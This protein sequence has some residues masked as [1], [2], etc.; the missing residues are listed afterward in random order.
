M[1]VSDRENDIIKDAVAEPTEKRVP[2]KK[3]TGKRKSGSRKKSV[4]PSENT[5]EKKAEMMPNAPKHAITQTQEQTT[6]TRKTRRDSQLHSK[7]SWITAGSK[8]CAM[9][10]AT[11]LCCHAAGRAPAQQLSGGSDD[12]R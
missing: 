4:Q 6:L 10:L 2:A 9:Q 5:T 12:G 1:A 3:Q 11:H 7:R 8:A